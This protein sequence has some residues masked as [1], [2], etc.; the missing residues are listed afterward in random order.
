MVGCFSLS[1]QEPVS[2]LE[3]WDEGQEMRAG[4]P[5]LN[6]YC[7]FGIC[8]CQSSFSFKCF[9]RRTLE[10]PPWSPSLA[11]ILLRA[12]VLFF[13]L[14]AC[15]FLSPRNLATLWPY[16]RGPAALG[17]HRPGLKWPSAVLSCTWPI[18][19]VQ[20]TFI[21]CKRGKMPFFSPFLSSQ[22]CNKR[23]I[24][25]RKAYTFILGKVYMT[26]EPS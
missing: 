3:D 13:G 19:L 2:G 24:S 21:L 23:R 20:E 22:S 14:V 9:Q 18:S 8:W 16:L 4:K 25:K 12:N 7:Y 26:L 10:T 15:S 1:V 11:F 17:D 5:F 6:R